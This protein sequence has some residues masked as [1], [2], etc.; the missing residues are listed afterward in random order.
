L[1]KK[2][3]NLVQIIYENSFETNELFTEVLSFITEVFSFEEIK[4][5]AQ[6]DS[7]EIALELLIANFSYFEADFMLNI[8]SYL[9]KFEK[10]LLNNNLNFLS[11]RTKSIRALAEIISYCESPE[12]FQPIIFKILET[13]LQAFENS[14]ENSDSEIQVKIKQKKI[15]KI[16]KIFSL[17]NALRQ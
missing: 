17:K 10:F 9:Q 12:I 14:N 8:N 5:Q 1:R 11:L 4:D 3:C 7:T 15:K 13:T 2:Y 6:L 16:K